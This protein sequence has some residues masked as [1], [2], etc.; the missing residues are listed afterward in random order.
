MRIS[1]ATREY[2]GEEHDNGWHE[3]GCAEGCPFSERQ[4]DAEDLWNILDE[5]V[6]ELEDGCVVEPDG[7]CPHGNRSPLLEMGLI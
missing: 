7:T 2:L 1:E 5:G 6:A 3:G 4:A